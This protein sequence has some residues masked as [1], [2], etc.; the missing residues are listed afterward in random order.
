MGC[1]SYGS[2][3]Q[4]RSERSGSATPRLR[5]RH[6]FIIKDRSNSLQSVLKA[7]KKQRLVGD[8]PVA[9]YHQCCIKVI[10]ID[11]T[12]ETCKNKKA[13]FFFFFS[14]TLIYSERTN[15]FPLPRQSAAGNGFLL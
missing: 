3:T 9:G 14:L 7:A 8:R 11:S 12:T 4:E 10:Q 6:A 15:G 2:A 5:G 13:P 1:M